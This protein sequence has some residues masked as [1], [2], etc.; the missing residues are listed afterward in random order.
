ML[1]QHLCGIAMSLVLLSCHY[2]L[3]IRPHLLQLHLKCV[4]VKISGVDPLVHAT[5][6]CNTITKLLFLHTIIR[7]ADMLDKAC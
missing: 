5:I 4:E 3:A 7:G 6:H 2:S 1:L